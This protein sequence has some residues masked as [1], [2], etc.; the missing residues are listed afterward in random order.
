MFCV[1][2]L[3]YFSSSAGF[4]FRISFSC[5]MFLVSC[6][7]FLFIFHVSCFIFMFLVSFSCFVFMFH[8]R[9]SFSCV[10]FMCHLHVPFSCVIYMCHLHVSFTCVIYMSF[11]CV[12]IISD[13]LQS[14]C[15]DWLIDYLNYVSYNDYRNDTSMAYEKGVIIQKNGDI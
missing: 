7:V 4:V 1:H 12:L 2:V 15:Q 9:V 14:A 3:S 10:I 5:F 6:F 11:S 13:L 8:F